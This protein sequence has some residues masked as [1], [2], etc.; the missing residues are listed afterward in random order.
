MGVYRY[1]RGKMQSNDV[2]IVISHS[3]LKGGGNKVKGLCTKLI[4]RCY[5]RGEHRLKSV[6]NI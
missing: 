1:R 5:R 3:D 2:D 6:L 4:Q